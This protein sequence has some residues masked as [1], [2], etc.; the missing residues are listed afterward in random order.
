MNK[1]QFEKLPFVKHVVTVSSTVRRVILVDGTDYDIVNTKGRMW[2]VFFSGQ[3]FSLVSGT[4]SGCYEYIAK[5]WEDSGDRPTYEPN[6]EETEARY[7][8][9]D[10]VEYNGVRLLI[11]DYVKLVHT[12]IVQQLVNNEYVAST[13][14][15][16]KV[17][18]EYGYY[19]TTMRGE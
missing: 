11:T 14:V 9:G 3:E 18:D 12:Y 1:T 15:S 10:I 7:Q 5:D 4:L 6:P 2:E 17:L 13:T 16:A 8:T 19:I